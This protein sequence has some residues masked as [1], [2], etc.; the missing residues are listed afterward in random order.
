MMECIT[1]FNCLAKLAPIGTAS[2]ALV[3]ALIALCAI[4]AQMVIARRRAAI[5]FFFKTEIDQTAVDLYKKFKA[6]ASLITSIPDPSHATRSDYY[7]IR[8]FL[9]ICELIAVGI[10]RGA[11]SK[12]VSQAYWG[13]VIP[14]SYLTAKQLIDAIRNTPGEGSS[15]TYIDL[16]KVATEWV[17]RDA[18]EAKGGLLWWL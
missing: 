3:A 8:T 17:K 15:H 11:F 18:K 4:W 16:E 9:N 1:D 10:K 14:D 7:D 2:I 6:K 13:D 12:S 5:D